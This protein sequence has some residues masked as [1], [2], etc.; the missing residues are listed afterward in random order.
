VRPAAPLMQHRYVP[1]GGDF[2]KFG[3]IAALAAGD[4]GGGALSVRLVWY[5]TEPELDLAGNPANRD[6][7]HVNY[8]RLAATRAGRYR[9]CAPSLYD[10]LAAILADGLRDVSVYSARGVLAGVVRV[11]LAQRSGRLRDAIVQPGPYISHDP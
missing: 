3:L 5:L 7:R 1:D 8:L 9:D 11:V 10:H 4:A 2:G 6:G